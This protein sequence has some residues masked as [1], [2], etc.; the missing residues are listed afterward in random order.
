MADFDFIGDAQVSS[1]EEVSRQL[2]LVKSRPQK[3]LPATRADYLQAISQGPAFLTFDFGIDGVSIEIAKYARVL[4]ALYQPDVD[5]RL[6]FIAGDFHPQAD[7][8]LKP[9]WSR[10]QID[11]INGWS[12][13]DEGKWFSALYL[14]DMPAGS[15][16]S[17]ELATEVYRQ[18]NVIAGELA[19]YLVT[20]NIGLLFPVN[21]ASNPGNL[22]L[23]LAL[24][25]A[26]EALGILVINSNH[27]FYWDGG[28][29]AAER[30]PGDEPG[31]RDHF[32]RNIHNE[33]FFSLFQKL[34]PWRGRRW[35]QVNINRRQSERLVK[36]HRFPRRKVR[37]ISTCVGD[38]LFAAYTDDDVKHARLRMAQILSN[39]SAEIRPR[40][41]DEH[42]REL[43]EW[44]NHQRP[45]VIGAR[46]GLEL[47]LTAEDIIYLLQPTRVI[48]RK[49]IERSVELVQA[50]LQGP[51]RAAFE[52][53]PDRQVV[54]HITGPTPQEHQ[55]D[56]ETILDAYGE[57]IGSLPQAI[58]ERVF[59]AFSSGRESHPSFDEH[60]F[61]DMTIADI[62]RL[63]TAVLVPSEIEGRGLP[64][65]ESG[66][67]GVPIICS[68]YRPEVVFADV[69]GEDLPEASRIHYLLF[70]E[71]HLP[72]AFL[73]E[74]SDLLTRPEIWTKWRKHNRQA[75]RSRFSV[76]AL[77]T[78]F[79]HLLV[80]S[81]EV[82]A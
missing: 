50:L 43:H 56:L 71:G 12:K 51:M 15:R 49:R 46:D 6:H 20:N 16:R 47:E 35:L 14:E 48:A 67:V 53:K 60:C 19:D 66:A 77:S 59:L 7:A 40:S 11:G 23:T 69:I 45:R 80:H 8:V 36:E 27:D 34:Y 28:K 2:A 64:I 73:E 63:A 3:P 82:A 25:L 65:I 21:V 76:A 24:A 55:G 18:A 9:Q 52:R 41:L 1:W 31:E 39:G 26:T 54:L 22:A 29:P 79:Q 74:A 33:P 32:F 70:P 5:A 81:Y 44:M 30:Q 38:T 4:E 17:S 68:R 13:W 37:E 58:A 42:R 72:E 57:L 61:E 62:F 10:C 78:A 75:I